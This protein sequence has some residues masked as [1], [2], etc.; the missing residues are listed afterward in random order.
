VQFNNVIQNVRNSD[1]YK[2][3]SEEGGGGGVTS[4]K[5]RVLN[6]YE[7]RFLLQRSH[8]FQ[9]SPDVASEELQGHQRLSTRFHEKKTPSLVFGLVG[10]CLYE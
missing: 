4:L 10:I 3:F 8:F 6:S 5:G 7:I 9:K 1:C 2:K